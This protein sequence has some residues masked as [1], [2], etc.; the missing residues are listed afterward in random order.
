[1]C[2]F[3]LECIFCCGEKWQIW[4]MS[5]W[6]GGKCLFLSLLLDISLYRNKAKKVGFLYILLGR[7]MTNMTYEYLR[8]WQVPLLSTLVLSNGTGWPKPPP[9]IIILLAKVKMLRERE[10]ITF[11]HEHWTTCLLKFSGMISKFY[12][13]D[14]V[15]I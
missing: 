1:M 14:P 4:L 2:P 7:K 10:N 12:K 6:G 9:S 3:Y 15:L 11:N 13:N 5:I 8:R